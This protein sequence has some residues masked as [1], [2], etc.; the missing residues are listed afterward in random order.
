MP[1]AGGPHQGQPGLVSRAYSPGTGYRA[2]ARFASLLPLR[3]ARGGGTG[4]LLRQPEPTQCWQL[5]DAP[6]V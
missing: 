4:C 6:G 2:P 1:P 5:I 3:R